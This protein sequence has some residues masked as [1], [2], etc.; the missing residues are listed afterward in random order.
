ME[1]ISSPRWP[2]SAALFLCIAA[3]LQCTGRL[4]RQLSTDTSKEGLLQPGT[5][6]W[7]R[8]TADQVVFG[9]I[10]LEVSGS[11]STARVD[12]ALDNTRIA[13]VSG[14][15]PW[16]TMFDTTAIGPGYHDLKATARDGSSRART[17]HTA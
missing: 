5:L 9:T 15:P 1:R 7:I 6:S 4:D 11:S 14:G 12:F 8:P 16:V 10:V 2:R 13:S 3:T 17:L